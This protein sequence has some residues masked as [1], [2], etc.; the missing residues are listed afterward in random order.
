MPQQSS[1]IK[2]TEN[3]PPDS[4]VQTSLDNSSHSIDYPHISNCFAAL[5]HPSQILSADSLKSFQDGNQCQS[6]SILRKVH[7][8]SLEIEK[9]SS[10]LGGKPRPTARL[11]SNVS[12]FISSPLNRQVM[13]E[14]ISSSNSC[15]DSTG[16]ILLSVN[17]SQTNLRSSPTVC[18]K[19]CDTISKEKTS[20]A[21]WWCCKTCSSWLSFSFHRAVGLLHFAMENGKYLKTFWQNISFQ[22][23][24][25]ISIWRSFKRDCFSNEFCQTFVDSQDYSDAAISIGIVSAYKQL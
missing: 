12:Q 17:T 9:K 18:S 20:E 4:K 5:V 10:I 24:K 7:Q 6:K 21:V 13:E 14:D 19:N 1:Q 2:F 22:I 15:S 3:L 16:G 25:R 8:S 11:L 23:L